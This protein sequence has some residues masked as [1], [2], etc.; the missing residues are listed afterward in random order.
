MGGGIRRQVP[1]G[2]KSYREAGRWRHWTA[3]GRDI[4]LDVSANLSVLLKYCHLDPVL[5]TGP[6]LDHQT[7]FRK[8]LLSV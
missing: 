5:K 4:F 2:G 1:D 6:F 3:E 8:L 7:V